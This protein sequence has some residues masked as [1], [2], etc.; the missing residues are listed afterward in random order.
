MLWSLL[1]GVP[2]GVS[3]YCGLIWFPFLE[4]LVNPAGWVAIWLC[5]QMY[6]F[7][8]LVVMVADVV[9]PVPQ[10]GDDPGLGAWV[11]MT[12]CSSLVSMLL[13]TSLIIII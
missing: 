13:I 3:V 4:C 10:T 11:V 7:R 6:Y 5:F 9:C 8:L 12:H 1:V 2:I